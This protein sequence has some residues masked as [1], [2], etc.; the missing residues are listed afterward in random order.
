MLP[1]KIAI[2]NHD[3][4]L[5][6]V[7]RVAVEIASGLADVEDYHVCLISFSGIENFFYKVNDKCEKKVNIRKRKFSENLRFRLALKCRREVKISRI[8]RSQLRGLVSILAEGGFECVIICQSDLTALIP[9]VKAKLPKIKVIAWQHND[10]EAYVTKYEYARLFISEY[11]TGLEAAD[12]VVCLT[13]N[14]LKKFRQHNKKTICI[15]NPVTLKADVIS[16]LDSF[17]IIYVGRL[18]IEHKGLDFLLEIIDLAPQCWNWILAGDGEDREELEILISEKKLMEKVQLV[19][20]LPRADLVNHFVSGSVFVSPSRW[21][22]MSLVVIEALNFGLPIVAF[23]IPGTREALDDGRCG[24]LVEKYDTFLF[25]QAV[26]KLMND[27]KMRLHYQRLSLDRSQ[28]FSLENI[29]P[30]WR[31]I[32]EG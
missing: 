10:Y 9:K 12:W 28:H 21:E 20:A 16:K 5:G 6:G 11:I 30:D 24:I 2:V 32:I 14:Y 18:A 3:F 27:Y 8:Y 22:G 13:K 7:Q 19:G 31:G 23:D 1:L 25:Y 26:E 29:L 17:N 4:S 15:Y